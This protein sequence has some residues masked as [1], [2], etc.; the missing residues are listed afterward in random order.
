[1]DQKMLP[2]GVDNFKKIREQNYFYVDKSMLIKELLDKRAEVN[3]FIRPRRFGKTLN[4]SM[5]RCYFEDAGDPAVNESNRCL[6]SGLDI[7]DAGER[8]TEQMG[9]YPVITLSLKSAKQPSFSS[10]C[11]K[12]CDELWREYERHGYVLSTL[13]GSRKQ[14]YEEILKRRAS[15][16]AYS[17]SLRFLSE[18]LQEYHGK[19]VIILIDEYDVPLENAYWSGF[20]DEM[21][22]FIR[23][24]FESALKTNPCLAFAVITGCL[25][26]SRESIFTGLN[27]LNVISILSSQYDEYFGF[28]PT[29]VD[30]MLH[31]YGK[32]GKRAIIKEWYDGYRFGNAAV[33]NPWSVINYVMDLISDDNALPSPYWANTSSNS[34][35]KNLV[36]RADASVKQELE[37][38]IAGGTIEKQVHEDITYDSIYD[39]E[40]S[41]WNFLFF[42]GYLKQISRRLEEENQYITMALP[43]MEVKYIY[44][45]TITKWFRDEVKS[46]DLSHL[47][48]AILSGDASAFQKELSALLQR[49]ISYMD[50]QEA[51]YHGF[52]MGVLGNMR[53]YFV[54]SN[55]EG[56]NGRLDI[57]IR[58]PDVTHTPVVLEL[59]ISNTFKGMEDAC[60]K[61]LDQIDE[62]GYDDWLPEEGYSDVWNYG[63]AFFRKQCRVMVKYKELL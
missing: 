15:L 57:V 27:N 59:K 23:S 4:M 29:E 60:R 62:K 40:D 14:Q 48:Q 9:V 45:N 21:V 63:I 13:S 7:M 61:A 5:L 49:G 12:L 37:L 3:L 58:H 52:L 43:N 32:E 25:R 30:Q 44:K 19:P 2:V 16:D 35:I 46:Q 54:K 41:L 39:S 6:F 1:M 50:N 8:Y 11:Y 47:Y 51:F 10:A 26:I 53:D 28:T 33:Y 17:G 20:Y 31:Y 36:E 22:G 42:T 55:R 18:V 24:L 38:L 34:I 56:G